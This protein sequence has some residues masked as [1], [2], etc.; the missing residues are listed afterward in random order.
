MTLPAS[1]AEALELLRDPLWRLRNLYFILDKDG[2]TIPFRPNEAQ[3]AFLQALWTRNIILKARQRGFSTLIQLFILDQCL[4]RENMRGG[5]T[6]QDRDTASAIFEDKL[7]FAYDHLPEWIKA[8]I[9]LTSDSTS[10]L[11]FSNGSSVRVG[12]SL[13]GGVLQFLHVSEFGK[14]CAT[15]PKRAKEVVTGSIQTVAKDGFVFIES[16][17]EGQEGK[18]YEMCRDAEAI[19]NEGRKLGKGDYRFHFFGWWDAPEYSIESSSVPITEKDSEYFDSIEAKIK[20]KIDIGH[21]LWYVTKRKN[22]FS[23]DEQMMKQEYPSISDEAFEVSKEGAYYTQQMT[24]VRRE[25]RIGAV[26]Y[27]PGYPVNTF[28]DIGN[29]D[30]TA[31]W[32]H[33]RVGQENRFIRFGEWWGE[34]YAKVVA[35]LQ[36]HGYVWG[37]HYLPHDA[38]HKRQGEVDNNSPKEKLENLGLRGIEIVPRVDAIQHGIQAT[39]DI[40]PSCCFDAV[41]CAAGIK[42]LDGYSQAW[43]A[44]AGRWSGEPK[45]DVHSEAAD[46]FRQFAQGYKPKTSRAP[47]KGRTG[48]A[49]QF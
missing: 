44:S 45:H 11:S 43:N 24:A 37:V 5:I 23:G 29:S 35:D 33:Q 1:N 49:N 16:T 47:A 12:T 7:K 19:K 34:T 25:G 22:D 14:I 27:L 38:A 36:R 42:H 3:E 4:F 46:A 17:A 41:N 40:F 18:F 20:R 15:N 9:R 6:A 28:W 8:G 10:K 2:Q 48:Y 30:G 39:R 31:V 13:R 26:P 32:L 21:R